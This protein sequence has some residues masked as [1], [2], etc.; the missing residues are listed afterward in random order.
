MSHTLFERDGKLYHNFRVKFAGDVESTRWRQVASTND[1]KLAQ[2]EGALILADAILNKRRPAKA[3]E[4]N[5]FNRALEDYLKFEGRT[6]QTFDRMA[7]IAK[8]LK[9]MGKPNP[10]LSIFNQ[11]FLG[12]MRAAM[13]PEGAKASTV[14]ASLFVPMKA[15][16]NHAARN[17]WCPL[18]R[19]KAPKL[20]DPDDPLY[21][22]PA[23]AEALIRHAPA[24][25]PD[26]LI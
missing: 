13:L 24:N 25:L 19:F 14:R 23:E 12:E 1:R 15:L 16:L 4:R 17:D 10:E 22:T 2:K 3:G 8:T 20:D 6:A 9:K 11:A 21:F 18:P 5:D 26:L 7:R